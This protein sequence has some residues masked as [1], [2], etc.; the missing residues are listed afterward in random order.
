MP[1]LFSLLLTFKNEYWLFH[2]T[3]GTFVPDPRAFFLYVAST[4]TIGCSGEVWEGEFL[5][6]CCW[7][8]LSPKLSKNSEKNKYI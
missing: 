1:T 2:R 7:G 6:P 5:Q 4:E 3:K 8:H